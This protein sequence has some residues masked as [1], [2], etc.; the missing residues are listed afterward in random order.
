[1]RDLGVSQTMYTYETKCKI[2]KI[3][4]KRKKK[5]WPGVANHKK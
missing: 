4:G 3:K 5:K 2:N 1:V